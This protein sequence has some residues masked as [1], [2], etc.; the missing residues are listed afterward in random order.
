MHLKSRKCSADSAEEKKRNFAVRCRG[1]T[2]SVNRACK[3]S[4]MFNG[5]G[6]S[7]T[8][9]KERHWFYNIILTMKNTTL[10]IITDY[11]IHTE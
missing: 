4:S 8:R 7:L 11:T 2:F 1:E 10:K 3:K 6:G 5:R 9:Q